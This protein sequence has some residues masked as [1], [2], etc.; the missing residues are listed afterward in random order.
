[1]AKI[2][3][4]EPA[5]RGTIQI[6]V[7]SSKGDVYII[8]FSSTVPEQDSVY[9]PSLLCSILD[10][11][12]KMPEGDLFSYISMQLARAK[13]ETP[14]FMMP[15]RNDERTRIG[16]KIRS[17]REEKKMDAK[18]LARLTDIDPANLSRIESGKF[19]AGLDTLSKIAMALDSKVDIIPNRQPARKGFSMRRNIWALPT[20]NYDP[21]VTIPA[22]GYIY[23]PYDFD[24][25]VR[26][27]DIVIT[28]DDKYGSYGKCFIVSEVGV[29]KDQLIPEIPECGFPGPDADAE[30]F[31]KLNYHCG[32][33]STEETIIANYAAAHLGGTPKGLAL[34]N[35]DI[36]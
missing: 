27:G 24:A 36:L 31:M 7:E 20:G 1:M 19:S 30:E 9:Y 18:T 23:W 33:S 28:C 16:K 10:D 25:E 13:M 8:G 2:L 34:L 11:Y 5:K 32:L 4:F 26:I 29:R 3:S 6:K 35:C 15:D 12:D 14:I 22:Y 17:I 21:I